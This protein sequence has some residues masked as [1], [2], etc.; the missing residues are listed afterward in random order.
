MF[1][2]SKLKSQRSVNIVNRI[3]EIARPVDST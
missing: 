1:L 3:T 2:G